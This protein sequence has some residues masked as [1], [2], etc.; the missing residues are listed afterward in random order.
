[1]VCRRIA[2][3]LERRGATSIEAREGKVHFR[4][5]HA[6]SNLNPLTPCRRGAFRVENVPGGFR[7]EY[8]LDLLDLL[9]W[10]SAVAAFL[11]TFGLIA[12]VHGNPVPLAL[13]GVLLGSAVPSNY[14]FYSWR[15]RSLFRNAARSSTGSTKG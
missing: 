10:T 4:A 2:A 13:V 15:T 6:T 7:I 3:S 11:C 12:L 9:L 8:E 5:E 14:A 1:M